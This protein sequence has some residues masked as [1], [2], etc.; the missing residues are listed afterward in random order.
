MK[1]EK[2]MKK[3][4]ENKILHVYPKRKFFFVVSSL[5]GFYKKET[6]KDY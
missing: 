5:K 1:N 2:K 4:C 6:A 3:K